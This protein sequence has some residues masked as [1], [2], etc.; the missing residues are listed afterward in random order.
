MSP[1]QQTPAEPPVFDLMCLECGKDIRF[2]REVIAGGM[3][4]VMYADEA[5]L[6]QTDFHFHVPR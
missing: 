6:E 2:S 1:D 5:G 3:T 4:V